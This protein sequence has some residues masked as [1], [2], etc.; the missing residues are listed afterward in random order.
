MLGEEKL[1]LGVRVQLP[2]WG[3]SKPY[4]VKQSVP[5]EGSTGGGH[6][7]APPDGAGSL[8][9]LEEPP[10]PARPLSPEKCPLQPLGTDPHTPLSHPCPAWG[11]CWC[12]A[13]CKQHKSSS[14]HQSGGVSSASSRPPSIPG[15]VKNASELLRLPQAV[16]SPLV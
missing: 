5:W 13:P 6:G 2:A 11:C 1:Q 12:P 9:G 10:A 14:S 7:A 4:F 15:R 16:R 8:T 3:Q